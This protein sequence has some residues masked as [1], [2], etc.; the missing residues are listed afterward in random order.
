MPYKWVEPEIV[1]DHKGKQ[2]YHVY[3]DDFED[4]RMTYWYTMNEVDEGNEFDIR[5]LETFQEDKPHTIA[6]REAI[7]KELI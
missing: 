1:V 6:L 4:Q 2:I 5:D 3:K 7:D